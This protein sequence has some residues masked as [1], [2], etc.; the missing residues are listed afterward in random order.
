MEIF[1]L[2]V[3]TGFLVLPVLGLRAERKLKKERRIRLLSLLGRTHFQGLIN[4]VL[5]S[6]KGQ[7]NPGLLL[8]GVLLG[9]VP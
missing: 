1:L 4:C 2:M 5:D 6:A 9:W 7:L 8:K 3:K